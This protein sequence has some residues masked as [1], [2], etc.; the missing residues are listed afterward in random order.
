MN[1]LRFALLALLLAA[2]AARAE[3]NSWATV[4]VG[5]QFGYLPG[6]APEA[7][8]ALVPGHQ[9]GV[10]MRAEAGRFLGLEFAAQ[11]DQ[12]PSTQ[13]L[14]I[15]SPRYQVG[16]IV[17]L[18]PTEWFDLY[19]AAGFGAHE[20]G[21][22]FT[23]AGATTSLHAGPGLEVFVGDHLAVGAD[24]RWRVP[25]PEYVKSQVRESLSTEPVDELVGLEVW[26]ANLHLSW[27][28]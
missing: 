22:L 8:Q 4:G 20:G 2:P 18:I 7:A 12:D 24:L 28:L 14:R 17:N 5:A 3:N 13:D 16:L 19:A 6:G 23:L 11:L 10:M 26:Q 1:A 25:G 15:L 27:Y 9:Y 21:D